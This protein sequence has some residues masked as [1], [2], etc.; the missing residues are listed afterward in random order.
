MGDNSLTLQPLLL[1]F[2]MRKEMYNKGYKDIKTEGKW[3]SGF[4]QCMIIRLVV[5][6]KRCQL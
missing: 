2:Y 1:L 3:N 4:T 5:C 6:V